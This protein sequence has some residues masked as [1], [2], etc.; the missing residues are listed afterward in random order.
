[1]EEVIDNY[2]TLLERLDSLNKFI[3]KFEKNLEL[4]EKSNIQLKNQMDELERGN[5]I[6]KSAHTEF[7]EKNKL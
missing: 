4:L 1:M 2:K 3:N 7:C 5:E 6:I